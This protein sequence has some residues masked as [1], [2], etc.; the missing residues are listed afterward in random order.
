M[1]K[2][3]YFL[4]SYCSKNLLP[5]T[6]SKRKGKEFSLLNLHSTLSK[7][8]MPGVSNFRR[9]TALVSISAIT[10][11]G[12]HN[13]IFCCTSGIFDPLAWT[14]RSKQE[15]I[16]VTISS[17][18]SRMPSCVESRRQFTYF[19][20]TLL[21]LF[22]ATLLLLLFFQQRWATCLSILLLTS[23]WFLKFSLSTQLSGSKDFAAILFELWISGII[24]RKTTI[25]AAGNVKFLWRWLNEVEDL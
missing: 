17:I 14:N 24:H 21:P 1:F 5:L 10:Q 9:Q 16:T 22:L 18:H 25:D 6:K 23:L 12:F 4:N 11:T 8:K 19:T 20:E 7:S 15:I 2:T 13:L 3:S